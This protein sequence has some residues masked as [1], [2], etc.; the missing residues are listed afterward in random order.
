MLFLAAYAIEIVLW[1]LLSSEKKMN[2]KNKA[3]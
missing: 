1:E 3:Y 2:N